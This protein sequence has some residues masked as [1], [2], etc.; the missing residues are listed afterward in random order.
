[1]QR[2]RFFGG[3]VLIR[4]AEDPQHRGS[5]YAVQARRNG[6]GPGNGSPTRLAEPPHQEGQRTRAKEARNLRGNA[7]EYGAGELAIEV[8][9]SVRCV[10]APERMADQVDGQS[11][12][13]R[14][15]E[16]HGPDDV[17]GEATAIQTAAADT[18]EIEQDG[19]EALFHAPC[20]QAAAKE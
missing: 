3:T 18:F 5:S 1:G 9:Q 11:G 6:P 20:R 14:P 8:C 4:V 7:V 19:V 2:L 15:R 12:E 16:R 13:P 17:V 10:V